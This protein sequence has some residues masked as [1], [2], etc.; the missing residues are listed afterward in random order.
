MREGRGDI[1]TG[2]N[3]KCGRSLHGFHRLTSVNRSPSCSDGRVSYVQGV[4]G[5]WLSY[6]RRRS[7]SRVMA[8]EVVSC[9]L[10]EGCVCMI[11]NQNERINLLCNIQSGYEYSIWNKGRHKKLGRKWCLSSLF[12]SIFSVSFCYLLSQL[13]A[14]ASYV[15]Y[16]TNLLYGNNE[17]FQPA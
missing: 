13:L 7:E 12:L 2:R 17:N 15:V 5:I 4:R 8:E 11:M 6:T 10:L 1:K 14:S 3:N 16:Y 9:W